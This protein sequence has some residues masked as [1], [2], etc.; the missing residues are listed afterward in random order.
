MSLLTFSDQ[1]FANRL[2]NIR[3]K[4]KETGLDALILTRPQ[5]I[6]YATGYRGA[7]TACGVSELHAAVIPAKG[8]PRLITRILE[9]ETTK[10]QWTKS[11]RLY[12]DQDN[13]YVVLADMVRES[14]N[15]TKAVG[16]EERALTAR[17]LRRTQAQ[18]P[19][20]RFVDASGLV[21]GV[22]AGP[23]VAES[24]CVRQAARIAD[25]GFKTGIGEIKEGVYPYEVIGKIHEAMYAAGQTD[26]D[27]ALVALWSGSQGGMMHDTSTT[28]RINKG[29]ICTVEIFGIH[30]QYKAGVQGC[31]YV[32][33]NPPKKIVEAYDL[34][35]RMHAK[36]KEAV[37]PGAMTGQIFDAANSVYRAAK[38]KDYYRRCGGSLGL[39]VF[40]LDLV[41]GNQDVLKPGVALLIQTLVDDPVLLTC[42]STVMVTENGCEEITQPLRGTLTTIS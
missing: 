12:L 4:M 40:A 5:N 7:H 31:V 21:E 37:K 34:V 15:D 30:K 42:A 33:D 1:E 28:E 14:G 25:I 3:A 36:A 27:M 10:A 41:K 22:A 17:Q 6:Y 20:A 35:T 39:T 19:N 16:V 23:S 24:E 2:A 26:F 18:L 13:P 29:D 38:G 11:P 8:E 9:A 32:G